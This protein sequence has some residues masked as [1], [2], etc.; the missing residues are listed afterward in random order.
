M[1]YKRVIIK[2]KGGPDLLE[3]IEEDLPEPAPGEVRVKVMA[4]G[5]AFGDIMWQTGTVPG[6]PKPPYTPGYDV[7][8][9]SDWA[10]GHRSDQDWRLRR[11]R[12][13]AR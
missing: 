13:R 7:V 2:N 9:A 6:S 12:L 11:V 8:R 1:I 5:V 4:A 10:D 3:V